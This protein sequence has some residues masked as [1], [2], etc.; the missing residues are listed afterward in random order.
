MSVASLPE[1]SKQ[2]EIRVLLP[3]YLFCPPVFLFIF[4]GGESS[5][6]QTA[7]GKKEQFD[8]KVKAKKVKKPSFPPG[9]QANI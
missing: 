3:R 5:E 9:H 6:E 8:S 7:E 2:A 1:L 4:W